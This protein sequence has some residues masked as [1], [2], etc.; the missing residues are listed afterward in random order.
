[1]TAIEPGEASVP[2][3]PQRCLQ[4]SRRLRN[5][6]IRTGSGGG[7][8]ADPDLAAGPVFYRL[9]AAPLN[10]QPSSWRTAGVYL[11]RRVDR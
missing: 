2:A 11:L 3:Q 8:S 6:L 5:T 4:T 1:L 7:C 10:D 9:G